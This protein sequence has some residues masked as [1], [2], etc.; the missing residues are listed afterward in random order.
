MMTQTLRKR[1]SLGALAAL[2]VMGNAA[3]QAQAAQTQAAQAQNDAALVKDFQ[4]RV[5]KYLNLHKITGIAKKT[6]DSPDKLAEQKQQ[7]AEKI[8][9][10]RPAAKQGDIFTPEIGAYFKKQIAATLQGPEGAKVRASL[11]RAEPLPNIRL[12]V[13]QRYPQKLPLQST[14]P[15]LLLNLPRL[16]G[17]L[18]Y[19]IVGS[20]LVL[21]D[22]L[23][24]L[25]VDLLPDAVTAS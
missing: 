24:N 8:R 17:E 18:Q 14:P 4:T 2:L 7:A 13:N 23:S 1:L 5:E 15:T 20:T 12:E 16:P 10:S 21:Y 11:R 22:T 25:I 9:E 6:T 3:A 19:R